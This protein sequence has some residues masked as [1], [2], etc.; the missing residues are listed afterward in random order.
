MAHAQQQ[1]AQE[2]NIVDLK[3]D[4]RSREV[5]LADRDFV[6]ISQRSMKVTEEET[7]HKPFITLGITPC[8][9]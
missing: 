8:L 3:L 9:I 2:V 1:E 5:T 7:S 4:V 6:A